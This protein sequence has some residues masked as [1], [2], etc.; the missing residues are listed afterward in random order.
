MPL[1][2]CIDGCRLAAMEMQADEL[3]AEIEL[4]REALRQARAA[5]VLR[6]WD[7]DALAIIDALVGGRPAEK[8]QA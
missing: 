5:H 8:E 3:V 6:A 7:D 1:H 2:P 4:L